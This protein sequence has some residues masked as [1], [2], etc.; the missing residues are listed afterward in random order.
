[1]PRYMTEAEIEERHEKIQCAHSLYAIAK[2]FAGLASKSDSGKDHRVLEMKCSGKDEGG[3]FAWKETIN[4]QCI[5]KIVP[6][7]F[8]LASDLR[9]EALD[10]SDFLEAEREGPTQ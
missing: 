6:L 4:G 8:A 3:E 7:F 5:G 2:F 10:T 9:S 1:M